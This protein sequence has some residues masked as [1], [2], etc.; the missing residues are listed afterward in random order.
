MRSVDSHSPIQGVIFDFGSTLSIARAGWPTIISAGAAALAAFLQEAGLLLPADFSHLWVAMLNFSVEQARRDGWERPADQV[1][2]ALLAS[3][4]YP[5]LDP[6]LIQQATDR[7][8]AVEDTL[9]GPAPGAAE[10]LATLHAAGYRLAVLSNTIGGRWVQ[11]WVDSYG[12]RDSLHAV[13]TSDQ[14]GFRKP[15]P[16]AFTIT[17]E[18]MGLADPARV[19]MVGD[20]PED[21]IAGAHRLRMRT[22]Q[23]ELAEDMSF[24]E[25]PRLAAEG[26]DRVEPDARITTL[27][28]LLPILERWQADER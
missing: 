13:V 2:S 19:V 12:F 27:P 16:E 6:A 11:Q 26:I 17:L 9:R 21:D 28:A 18:R 23:I 10:L 14:I 20:T 15:R 7:F 24:S 22:V 5:A 3:Q 25:A 8:F 1:L 4:G